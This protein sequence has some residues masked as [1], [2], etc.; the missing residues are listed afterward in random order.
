MERERKISDWKKKAAKGGNLY[1]GVVC[2]FHV[3]T[4]G[5]VGGFEKSPL[6][7]GVSTKLESRIINLR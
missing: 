7:G 3:P 1:H 6:E 2:S 5:R 4:D